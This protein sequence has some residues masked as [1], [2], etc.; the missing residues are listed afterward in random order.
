MY[1]AALFFVRDVT[2][3]PVPWV[4]FMCDV[5]KTHFYGYTLYLMSL[6]LIFMAIFDVTKLFHGY[7]LCV[8]SLRVHIPY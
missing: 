7:N 8:I 1:F 5:T 3:D 4:C 6:R 2:M